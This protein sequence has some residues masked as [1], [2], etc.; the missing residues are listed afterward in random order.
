[1]KQIA[2]KLVTVFALSVPTLALGK[3]LNAQD[4]QMLS[5]RLSQLTPKRDAMDLGNS[6]LTTCVLRGTIPRFYAPHRT[7]FISSKEISSGRKEYSFNLFVIPD[8]AEELRKKGID[9]VNKMELK[10][11]TLT[12]L[13]E[14]GK[15]SAYAHLENYFDLNILGLNGDRMVFSQD[16]LIATEFLFELWFNRDLDACL[17]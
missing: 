16:A 9:P 5:Y 10:K 2:F 12:L 4:F 14:D 1:M 8:N 11:M 7:E 13:S 17:R 15:Y 6:V 3:S